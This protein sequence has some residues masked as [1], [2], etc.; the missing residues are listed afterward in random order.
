MQ[1]LLTTCVYQCLPFK[2][3]SLTSV[4]SAPKEHSVQDTTAIHVE[5]EGPNMD[6]E[7][8]QTRLVWWLLSLIPRRKA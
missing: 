5:N 2:S 7:S 3:S 4:E 8:V 6:L 1:Y